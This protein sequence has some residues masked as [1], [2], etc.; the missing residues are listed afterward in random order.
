MLTC[1]YVHVCAYYVRTYVHTYVHSTYFI[2]VCAYVHTVCMYVHSYL[3]TY[4]CMWNV[5]YGTTPSLM[6]HVKPPVEN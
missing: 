1:T 3:R 4:M 6:R 2:Y 5:R